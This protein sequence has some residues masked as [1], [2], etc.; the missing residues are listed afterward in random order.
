MIESIFEILMKMTQWPGQYICN[1]INE[2]ISY[3]F[4]RSIEI[5]QSILTHP[6]SLKP[7]FLAPFFQRWTPFFLVDRP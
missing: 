4:Q 7:F 5:D 6:S 3:D 2:Q 1:T